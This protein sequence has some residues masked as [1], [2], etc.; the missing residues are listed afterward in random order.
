METNERVLRAELRAEAVA[1]GLIRPAA[2]VALSLDGVKL[3]DGDALEVPAGYWDRARA[4]LPDLFRP[5]A[6]TSTSSA[7]AP[8]A[9]SPPVQMRAA[10]MTESQRRQWKI[11]RGIPVPYRFGG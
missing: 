8:P 10:D 6:G 5:V 1:Q 4:E 11:S 9:K 3:G 7:H 2:S